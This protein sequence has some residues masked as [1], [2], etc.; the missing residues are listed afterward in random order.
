MKELF[1]DDDEITRADIPIST[2]KLLNVELSGNMHVSG[3]NH[4]RTWC[5]VWCV[6]MQPSAIN[7]I[8][9]II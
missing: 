7:E 2:W 8:N 4:V 6:N 1:R 9:Y 5:G 3:Q